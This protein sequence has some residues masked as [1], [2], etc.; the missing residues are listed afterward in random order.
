MEARVGRRRPHHETLR[1]GAQNPPLSFE[2]S[3]HHILASYV[4]LLT[5]PSGSSEDACTGRR[6]NQSR[7]S[8]L[9]FG[10]LKPHSGTNLPNWT[11]DC[12]FLYSLIRFKLSYLGVK[13]E[14]YFLRSRALPCRYRDDLQQRSHSPLPET[15]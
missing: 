3:S 12:H 2:A 14:H 9:P 15:R 5:T 10:I 13:R 8:S 4:D 1:D 6:T 7:P 11:C